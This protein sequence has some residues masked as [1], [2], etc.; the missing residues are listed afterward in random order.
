[1]DTPSLRFTCLLYSLKLISSFIHC[2]DSASNS[3][4]C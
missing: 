2:W 3:E 1:L 4:R